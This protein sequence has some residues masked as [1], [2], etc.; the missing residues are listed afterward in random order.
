MAALRSSTSLTL[1]FSLL[2]AC[3]AIGE[4]GTG[5]KGGPGT[6]KTTGTRGDID[7]CGEAGAVCSGGE[8]ECCG[9][10]CAL[11]RNVGASASAAGGAAQGRRARTR[12]VSEPSAAGAE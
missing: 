12:N 7:V 2:A 6:K 10:E 1:V 4:P 5:G 9:G 8:G 11:R 3:S